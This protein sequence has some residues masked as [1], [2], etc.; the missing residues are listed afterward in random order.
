[1]A[2]AMAVMGCKKAT[3]TPA[4][5]VPAPGPSQPPVVAADFAGCEARAM[6]ILGQGGRAHVT[7]ADFAIRCADGKAEIISETNDERYPMTAAEWAAVWKPVAA[8]WPPCEPDTGT[9]S[10]SI[11][12]AD[13]SGKHD[14]GCE[15]TGELPA[16]VQAVVDAAQAVYDGKHRP[17]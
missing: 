13:E 1:M 10:W 12:I 5:T 15:E 9:L 6:T 4:P 3:S 7:V 17:E 11:T 2:V 8:T 16:P 14:F